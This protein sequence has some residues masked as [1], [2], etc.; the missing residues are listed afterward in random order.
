MARNGRDAE[1]WAAII[2]LQY[3]VVRRDSSESGCCSQVKD[4]DAALR[5]RDVCLRD[6]DPEE[7]TKGSFQEQHVDSI[8]CRRDL[9]RFRSRVL[10]SNLES[11]FEMLTNEVL[12]ETSEQALCELSTHHFELPMR[13][14]RAR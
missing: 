9:V 1:G 10:I 3:E 5:H 7:S 11:C 2:H 8:P 13:N 14:S 12:R 4:I 6:D